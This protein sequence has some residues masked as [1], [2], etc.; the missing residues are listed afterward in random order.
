MTLSR[1][2]GVLLHPTSLPG[3]FGIGGLGSEAR[4]FLDFLAGAGQ[5]WW[6]LLPIG[7]TG[8]GNSPYQ[9]PSTFAG[10]PLLID[11]DDLVARG[12]LET[13]ELTGEPGLLVDHVDF[14]AAGRLK[15]RILRAAFERFEAAGAAPDYDAFRERNRA[16]LDDYAFYEAIRD[17]HGRMPWYEWE[18]DLAARDPRACARWRDR[19]DESIRYHAF[20]QYVFDLQWHSLRAA[21]RER[22]ILLI[23]D[24]PIF[25]AH[26]SADVWSHP[27]LYDLDARGWPRFSAGVPPDYFSATGQL[28]GNPL[29][30]WEAHARD[31]YAWWISRLRS[32]LDRVDLVR[33]DH[34]R[35][36]AAYW[37]VPAGSKTAETGEWVPAPGRELFTALHRALRSLPV[38]A[39]DLGLITPDVEALRDEF[40]LP[41]MRVIQFGFDPDP[42]AHKHLPHRYEPNCVAYTGTHDNDTSCGWFHSVD[43]ATTQSADAVQASRNFALRYL[44]SSGLEVHWDLIRAVLASVAGTVIVPLQ[45]LLGL[46]SRARMNLPGTASG[47]WSWRFRAGAADFRIRDRLAELTACYDRWNGPTPPEADPRFRPLVPDSGPAG[48][49]VA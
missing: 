42:G 32:V 10:N 19:L 38:I 6:Q 9:S 43:V 18:E 8:Y 49:A 4:A 46:D 29:Y 13:S 24:L 31:G 37:A 34:F 26:D 11:P 33:V 3:R 35:G 21:C 47:N 17:A 2:S 15:G 14:D 45:D 41:G 25:V 39:E 12:W 30:R 23:G 40:E 7:P 48:D 5:T 22:G 1:G 28:W 36:F 27:E 20:V 16:W 44:G